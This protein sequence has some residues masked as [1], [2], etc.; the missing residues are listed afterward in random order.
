MLC[1]ATAMLL[2]FSKPHNSMPAKVVDDSIQRFYSGHATV[3]QGAFAGHNAGLRSVP[4]KSESPSATAELIEITP[5]DTSTGEYAWTSLLG[6]VDTQAWSNE[7][8][9]ELAFV[10]QHDTYSPSGVFHG[11]GFPDIR[12][13]PQARR[14]PYAPPGPWAPMVV[15]RAL[16]DEPIERQ[17]I[18]KIRC[19]GLKP[20]AVARRADHYLDLI[21]AYAEKYEIDAQLVKAV[22]AVESCFNNK[23]LSKVGAQGLMQL[24][25]DTA[26]WLKVQDPHDPA[27]NVRGGVKYLAVLQKEFDRLELVLAAYNAGP[28][29]VR[30]YK[31]IPPF[32][33][34][35]AYVTKV[36][37]N[38]RRYKAA[39]SL[40]DPP[41]DTSPDAGSANITVATMSDA[42]L[43]NIDAQAVGP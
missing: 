28:G 33:E 15:W 20:T 41:T 22:I 40:L 13:Y 24:M 31:G 21:Y 18:A 30:R 14:S 8:A 29:N 32:A 26:K 16:P 37:A 17:P 36:Q 23:A 5:P 9:S 34:T 12:T 11:I 43:D 38:Y 6:G 7:S 39:K 27:Q 19:M 10:T 1:M 42:A 25:P 4:E 35:R 3:V 2:G